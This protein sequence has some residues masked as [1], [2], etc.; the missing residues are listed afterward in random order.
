MAIGDAPGGDDRDPHGI[1]HLRDQRQR[2]N[3]SGFWGGRLHEVRPMPAGLGALG[4]NGVDPRA[5]HRARIGRRGNH[6]DHLDPAAMTISDELRAR[7]SHSNTEHG[8]PLVKNS[9]ESAWNEV[10]GRRRTGGDF[11]KAELRP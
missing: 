1:D 5:F 3:S 8:Y 7:A 4:H 11:W 10:R 2:S 6:G 9:L